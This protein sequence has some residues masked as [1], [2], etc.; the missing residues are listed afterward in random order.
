M[1]FELLKVQKNEM[2]P[3]DGMDH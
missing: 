1:N 3:L 2:L